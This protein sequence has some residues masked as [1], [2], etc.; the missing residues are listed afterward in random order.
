MHRSIA[1]SG[2]KHELIIVSYPGW[3][4]RTQAEQIRKAEESISASSVPDRM[5]L[6]E[7]K[8]YAARSKTLYK[9]TRS[10]LC[11]CAI[12]VLN[13]TAFHGVWVV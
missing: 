11:S 10:W 3:T 12:L 5:H 8:G 6:N 13:T 9:E 2:I 1:N 7:N 4:T